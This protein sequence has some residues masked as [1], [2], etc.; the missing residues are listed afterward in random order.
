MPHKVETVKTTVFEGQKPGTSGLR[1]PVPTFQTPNYTENFIQCSIDAGLG[2]K[3]KG[4]TLVVGGDGR[5]LC[6]HVV[7]LIIQIA[8]AN[9]VHKLIVGQNGFFSTPAVSCII[10]KYKTDGGIILTASHNPGGPNG[11]FGIK[12]NIAN[13]GPA[14]EMITEKI[15]ELTKEIKKY[16]I[17]PELKV[18]LSSLGEQEFDIEGVGKFVIDVI[19]SVKDYCELMEQIFD[20]ESIRNLISGQTTGTSFRVLIDSMHGATGPYVMR[21]IGEKLGARTEDLLHCNPL[22][23]FGGFHPDPNLTYAASLVDL[24]RK[25][26]HDLGAAF[27]GDGDR[28]MILGKNGF[29]V[30]PSDSLAVLANNLECIPYFQH[31]GIKGFARSMPTAGAVDRFTVCERRFLEKDGIWA[32]LAWLSVLAHLKKSVEE[33]VRDHWKI[34]GRNVFTRYTFNHCH[35]VHRFVFEGFQHNDDNGDY[36]HKN[37]PEKECFVRVCLVI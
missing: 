15:F 12:F 33:I 37:D 27:D 9:G 5:Y 21:I 26:S 19:D 23:D 14:P 30:T 2:G 8:A 11:D 32:C 13:G 35:V 1:K 7:Q 20:F 24:M 18:D 28:N 3:K 16:H 10:R 36:D 34:Y 4:A 31:S 6:D 25:G 17:C 22:A 29:F